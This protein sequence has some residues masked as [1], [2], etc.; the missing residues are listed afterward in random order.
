MGDLELR[1]MSSKAALRLLGSKSA[2]GFTSTSP[3][4]ILY[5]MLTLSDVLLDCRFSSWSCATNAEALEI[6]S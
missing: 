1:L 3:F 2:A 5:I 6:E 4:M